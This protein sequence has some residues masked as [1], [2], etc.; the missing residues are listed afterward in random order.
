MPYDC[1]GPPSA[2]LEDGHALSP[3]GQQR[4]TLLLQLLNISR[5][6]AVVDRALAW[7]I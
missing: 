2:I 1:L 3:L 7:P 6:P 5:L 4:A